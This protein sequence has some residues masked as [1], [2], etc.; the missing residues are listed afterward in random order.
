MKRALSALLILTLLVVASQAA[1]AQLAGSCWPKFHR[2]AANTGLG[3][4]GGTGSDLT[5]IYTAGGAIKSSPVVGVDGTCYFACDDGR[6]YAVAGSGVKL[7]DYNCNCLGSP[8]P[9]IASDGTIYC[10]SADKYLYAINPN[11]TLKWKRALTAKIESSI[12]I[13]TDGT[14]YFGAGSNLVAF[15][16]SGTQKWSFATGGTVSSTPAIGSDGTI[17]FGSA[18]AGVYAQIGRASCRERVSY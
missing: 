9:A 12:S 7:W 16:S 18:D 11:G 4:Y 17:Y 15:N 3:L 5:W 8:S 6:L 2:D 13:G 14:V 10:P 1:F